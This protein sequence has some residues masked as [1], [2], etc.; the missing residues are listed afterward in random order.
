MSRNF[1][2]RLL[3]CAWLL[4]AM[5]IAAAA[6]KDAQTIDGWGQVV[7]PKGDCKVA[8]KAGVLSI[9]VAGGYHD[10]DP[11]PGWDNLDAPRV[12]QDVHGDFVVQVRVKKFPMPKPGTGANKVKPVAFVSSGL[13]VWQDSEN[14]IRFERGATDRSFTFV[15]CYSGG[16]LGALGDGPE[17]SSEDDTFLRIARTKGKFDFSQSNDGETWVPITPKG[18]LPALKGQLNVGVIVVNATTREITHDF[19]DVKLSAPAK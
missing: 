12:V 8:E 6:D 9:T 3:S 14:F 18:D 11:R 2:V 17:T 13:V 7:D 4:T 19:T 16:Q 15:E 10:L 1:T 5:S